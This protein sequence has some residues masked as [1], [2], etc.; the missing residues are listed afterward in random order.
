MDID[1]S[2]SASYS[3]LTIWQYRV[4]AFVAVLLCATAL[5]APS[6]GCRSSVAIPKL[7]WFHI[8]SSPFEAR[9]TWAYPVR[10]KPAL[11][12]SAI[13]MLLLPP[14]LAVRV[15][16]TGVVQARSVSMFCIRSEEHTSE[17]QSLRH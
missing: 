14:C 16:T 15:A 11:A 6:D 8:P 7:K 3:P 9:P 17:L 5:G 12:S 1:A 2:Q 4:A 10:Y 13:P